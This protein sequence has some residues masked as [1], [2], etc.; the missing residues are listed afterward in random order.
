MA[1]HG[2]HDEHG[3]HGGAADRD[4]GVDEARVTAPMAAFAA[5]E[6]RRGLAVLAVGLVVAFLLP[7]ALA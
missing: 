2:D 1:E 7:L 4:R 5:D 3:D 6:V